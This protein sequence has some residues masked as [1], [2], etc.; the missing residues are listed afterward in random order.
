MVFSSIPF[1][2]LF[3]PV[4][5][6]F[7]YL[8][9]GRVKNY[10]LL[11]FSLLFYAWGE[12]VYIVLMLL[13]T[14][15]NYIAGLLLHRFRDRTGLRKVILWT[16]VLLSVAALGYYKYADFAIGTINS[17]FGTDIGKLQLRL[18]IG[19]S[20]FTFQTLSYT[21]DL[22][23]KEIEVEKNY[24]FFL[25][26]VSMFPQLIAGPIVR[27]STVQKEIR[28]RAITFRGFS[29]GLFRFSLG[30]FKKV[31]IANQ[32]GRLWDALQLSDS[33]NLSVMGAWLGLFSFTLQ[34][35]FD[36][37]AYS[38]M[39]IGMGEMM[40]FHFR[41]NFNYPLSARSM[42]DFW[43]RWHISMSGWF[44]DYIYIPLGGNRGGRL[45]QMRNLLIVWFT[46]GL[47]HGASWNFVLWGM[48]HLLFLVLE[49]TVYG[50]LLE[51]LPGLIR[52]IYTIVVVVLGFGIF[53]ITDFSK[54][55]LYFASAFGLVRNSLTDSVFFYSLNQYKIL[56]P[57]ALLLM[58]PIYP[59]LQKKLYEI[60]H[61]NIRI[62]IQI[63]ALAGFILCFLVSISALVAD[64]YN[65]FLYFR[66]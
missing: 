15:V 36:F 55:K 41:E 50:R 28:E 7:Y 47:W 66:F 2:F 31:L 43:R 48:F 5:L 6:L 14:F 29:E 52:H 1:I 13:V 38:D 35:Y 49:K 21:I 37:S 27:F 57:L 18:P 30:L 19:I 9:P 63:G 23:K 39:A 60:R 16:A 54:M 34:L 53:A 33:Y 3:L 46:T 45:R 42:T 51:K 40:G 11:L 64:S 56:F 8:A 20:F 32:M 17:L 10:I 62:G 58:F 4:F 44:R 61:L 12:P 59:F 65:P 26:Y 22:Y 24:G 25:M